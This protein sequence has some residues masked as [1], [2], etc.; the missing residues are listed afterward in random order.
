SVSNDREGSAVELVDLGTD[1]PAAADAVGRFAVSTESIAIAPRVPHYALWSPDGSVLSVVRRTGETLGISCYA[2]DGRE[3]GPQVTGSPIFGAWT[4]DSRFLV[5]HAGPRVS[6]IETASGEAVRSLSEAAVGFRAPAVS[7]SGRIIYA[8]PRDGVL[9][10]MKTT[11]MQSE[12][13]ELARFG[14]GG[15]LAFRPGS[16]DLTV[17]VASNAEA[18]ALS[19][20]WLIAADGH[21]SRITRGPFVA[22]VWSPK[23]DRVALV[24]PTQSGDGRHYVRIVDDSGEELCAS[25]SLVPS[26]EFR[27]WLAF[28]DQYSQSHSLWDA[29]GQTLL[30]AGRRVDDSVHSSLGDPVG[31]MVYAWRADRNQTLELVAP[32]VSG[33]FNRTTLPENSDTG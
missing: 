2:A 14:S 27:L 21:R 33:F 12:S 13:V 20:L 31:D 29:A 8:E 16:E 28:F 25:E 32:G 10:L 7:L 6:L 5:V 15:V 26:P 3:L 22:Y 23:G 19:E 17:A 9:R 24:A 1:E 30:L 4:A 11:I 18:G